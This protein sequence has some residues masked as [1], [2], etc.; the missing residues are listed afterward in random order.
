MKCRE[1]RERRKGWEERGS[2][3]LL[4]IL[5]FDGSKQL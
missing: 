5:R 2:R 1:E 3:S 4:K